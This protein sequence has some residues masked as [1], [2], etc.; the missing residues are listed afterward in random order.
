MKSAS[1]KVEPIASARRRG[2]T[3]IAAVRRD[4]GDLARQ[5]FQL[6]L[7]G[8]FQLSGAK[9]PITLGSK[10]LCGLMA[11]L[12]CAGT[13]P[14]SREKLVNLLWGSHFEAQARQNLRQALARLRR[15]LGDDVFVSHDDLIS[16]RGEI[17]GNDVERFVVL[18]GDGSRLA[19]TE[20][21]NLYRDTFL[22]DVTIKEEAWSDWLLGQRRRLESLAVDANVRLGEEELREGRAERALDAGHRAVALDSLREDAHRVIIKSLAAI[23]RRPEALR[24]YDQLATLLKRELGVEPDATTKALAKELRLPSVQW[25][26]NEAKPGS[27]RSL[28]APANLP[29]VA[30]LPFRN[31][32]PDP[33]GTYFGDGM[34]EDIIVSLSSLRELF[35]I[36]RSS[37][38]SFRGED[39][40]A[41]DIGRALGVRYVVSGTSS[42][43]EKS[44]AFTSS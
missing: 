17:V 25:L 40:D 27:P 36:S 33:A 26:E 10:K 34:V 12:A 18:I 11:L 37:T 2:T 9:G 42:K 16:L 6:S 5:K 22:A 14:Y 29:S 3:A 19:L 43:L 21:S 20:A 30:V 44:C 8:S 38:L 1:A 4:A 32:A 23:G 13:T 31:R 41:R 7:L 35:V 39:L 28:V 15:M 24:Q